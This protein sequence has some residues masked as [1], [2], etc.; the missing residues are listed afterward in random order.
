MATKL[1]TQPI[2]KYTNWA[3]DESTN[4]LPVS[5]EQVQKYI[6]D[7][8]NK[9]FGY[10][11]FDKNSTDTYDEVTITNHDPSNKY[12]IFAD[13]TDFAKWAS[14]PVD[15]SNLILFSFDAPAPATIEISDKGEQTKTLL[16]AD[17]D[18]AVLSFKYRVKKSDGSFAKSPMAYTISINNNISGVTNLPSRTLNMGSGNDDEFIQFKYEDISQ[19]LKSGINNITITLTSTLFNVSTTIIYQYNVL[20]LKLTSDFIYSSGISLDNNN[21]L[22]M[23]L[24]AEGMG[25]K[26][27]N[28]FI[29][30]ELQTDLGGNNG[31]DIYIGSGNNVQYELLIPFKNNNNQYKAWATPGMHTIQM[32][33]FI[34]DGQEQIKSK[35]LYYDFILTQRGMN[36]E[37]YI[38]FDREFAEGTIIDD[39]TVLTIETEQ[40]SSFQVKYAVYDTS[41]SGTNEDGSINVDIKLKDKN[42]S[43]P[44]TNIVFNTTASV[45]SGETSIFEYKADVAG[46][47]SLIITNTNGEIEN[48]KIINVNIIKSDIEIN[49]PKNRVLYFD[50]KNRSNAEPTE[51]RE[52]WK[53]EYNNGS[54]IV[55]YQAQFN[56]VLWNLLNGWHDN[57]LVLNNGATVT[58]PFNFFELQNQD[59]QGRGNGITFEIDFETENVQDDDAIIMEYG[60]AN[61]EHIYIKAC[62]AELQSSNANNNIHTNYKDGSRQKIQFIFGY[63]RPIENNDYSTAQ[64]YEMPYLMYIVVNGILDRVNQFTSDDAIGVN[65]NGLESFT[66]G[67]TDNKVTTKIHSISIYRRALTLDECADNYIADSDD[68]RKKYLKN[69]IYNEDG[70]TISV[71]K[72]LSTNVNVPVMTIYGDITNSIVQVFNKKSNVPVDVLYQ[73]PNYPEFNFFAR[74]A[75]LSNQGTSSMNYPRRNFRLYFNKVSDNNTLYGFASKNRYDY[76]TRVWWGLTDAETIGKIQTDPAFDLDAAI[77]LNGKT[78]TPLY[79][80]KA[81]NT[82]SKSHEIDKGTAIM[83]VHSGIKIFSDPECKNQIGKKGKNPLS[84]YLKDNPTGKIY[85]QGAY[86]RFKTKDLF[87][88]RWTLKCDYAESSMCH[89]AGIGRLWG[90]VMKNVEVGATGFR[91][92]L[93]GTKISDATPGITNAQNAAKEYDAAHKGQKISVNGKE[94]DLVFGDIR[95][96]CDGYPIIII[97]RPRIKDENGY[98]DQYDNPVFLGLYNIM[99][100]KGSTPLFG[101]EDL[102]DEDGNKRFT[103]DNTECWEC[104]QNGSNLA[105]MNDMITDDTDGSTVQYTTKYDDKG[106]LV[107]DTGSD[108]EDRPIFKTYEARWPDN[109]DLND[110]TT[111]NL[112]T[113]IR[114]VNFCKDALSVTVDG[115]DGYALSD[116]AKITEEQAEQLSQLSDASQASTIEGLENLTKWNGIIYMGV[117]G[118]SY[119]DATTKFYKTNSNGETIYDSVTLKPILLDLNDLDDK[120]NIIL[121]KLVDGKIYY[122]Q[123]YAAQNVTGQSFSP[124]YE[125]TA[126]PSERIEAIMRQLESNRPYVFTESVD[127]SSI[128]YVPQDYYDGAGNVWYILDSTYK[129]ENVKKE[130]NNTV[131]KDDIRTGRVLTYDG[132]RW[133]NREEGELLHPDAYVTVYITPR[134]S[135]Y[136]YVNEMGNTVN[137]NTSE[138]FEV[139]VGTNT[140]SGSFKGATLFDYFKDKK[141]EH[142][143]IWKL[144]C[145]YV[146]M[147]RFAAVDQVIKNTMMTTEDGRHYYFI[148]YDNDTTLGVR[149]DGYLAYDWK[150]DRETYDKSIGSFCYAGFGSVLWNLL[151]Q[152]DDFLDK[153]QKVAT[154]MVASNVLTYDIALDMFNNK[155]AGIWGERLYNNSE[156]YKYIGIYTDDENKDTDAYNPYKNTKYL[157]FLQGSRASHREWW[158]RHRFDLYDSKWSAGE[159]ANNGM[160]IYMSASASPSRPHEMY[161]IVS[162]S[163]YYY[164]VQTNGRTLGN[165]FVELE[166]GAEW[167]P[168]TTSPLAIGDPMTILGG[169]NIE[170]LDFSKN[171]NE[172]G[173]GGIEFGWNE[174]KFTSRMKQLII[175]GND[176][177]TTSPIGKIVN[178]HKLT[179]LEVLDIRTCSRLNSNPD[180]STLGA[181]RKFLAA[182]SNITSFMPAKGLILEEVSLPQTITTIKL[183]TLSINS[184]D[185]TPNRYLKSV[186]IYNVNGAAFEGNKI[187]E[188]ILNWYLSI[189]E[190]GLAVSEYKCKIGFSRIEMDKEYKVEDYPKL[191]A[192]LEE[193]ETSISCI[194]LL[195]KIKGDFNVSISQD[196]AISE[197]FSVKNGIIKIWG[198]AENKGLTNKNYNTLKNSIYTIRGRE[199]LQ[200][201]LW[202]DNWFTS[203]SVYHFDAEE[204]TF[205]SVTDIDGYDAKYIKDNGDFNWNIVSGQNAKINVIMFP[206]D[207]TRKLTFTPWY[208]NN[209]NKD[210]KWTKL[211]TG[212]DWIFELSTGTQ[213]IN[214]NNGSAT[215]KLGEN[216]YTSYK[217]TIDI[218]DNKETPQKTIYI[219][220]DK[221]VKPTDRDI[222]C[223]RNDNGTIK[224]VTSI[225]ADILSKITPYEYTV[226]FNLDSTDETVYESYDD[227]YNISINKIEASFSQNGTRPETESDLGTLE[228]YIDEETNEF[229]IRYTPKIIKNSF[230]NEATENRFRIYLWTTFNDSSKTLRKTPNISV[231][232]RKQDINSINLYYD[233]D[234][235]YI[236]NE[237]NTVFDINHY[238][239]DSYKSRLTYHY[240]I[241]INPDNYNVPIQSMTIENI[242]EGRTQ[243]TAQTGTVENNL[244][245]DFDIVYN[246]TGRNSFHITEQFIITIVTEFKTITR[247]FNVT[248]GM[249]LPDKIKLF[250]RT[251]KTG[252]EYKL[253]DKLTLLSKND[254]VAEVYNYKLFVYTTLNNEDY[255]WGASKADNKTVNNLSSDKLSRNYQYSLSFTYSDESSYGNLLDNEDIIFNG[256]NANQENTNIDAFSL[257]FDTNSM[258]DLGCKVNYSITVLGN[259]TY[260]QNF[261]LEIER[262][263]AL[264]TD[265]NYLNLKSYVNGTVTADDENSGIYFLDRNLNIYNFAGVSKQISSNGLGTY[266]IDK[267]FISMLFVYDKPEHGK[268]CLSLDF[269]KLK[270]ACNWMSTS[271]TM[272][273]SPE[274][275]FNFASTNF[276]YAI[277]GNIGNDAHMEQNLIDNCNNNLYEPMN[278]VNYKYKLPYIYSK[279]YEYY[280]YV[281]YFYNEQHVAIDADGVN[282]PFVIY[283]ND[284]NVYSGDMTQAAKDIGDNK[285]QILPEISPIKE[286]DKNYI[287]ND[288]E[289]MIFYYIN[290]LKS[291]GVQ[292]AICMPLSS[293]E[294]EIIYNHYKLFTHALS[295]FWNNYCRNLTNYPDNFGELLFTKNMIDASYDTYNE[296]GANLLPELVDKTQ[297]NYFDDY[298]ETLKQSE[299]LWVFD[300]DDLTRNSNI[301]YNY[302]SSYSFMQ[303]WMTENE[304]IILGRNIRSRV[305]TGEDTS[306]YEYTQHLLP[307]LSN[308]VLFGVYPMFF[309]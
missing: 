120:G 68:I 130:L 121:M 305:P 82:K 151:E 54:R 292:N 245:K 111:N 150:I 182:G 1:W 2:N 210:V 270:K 187:F 141:Y 7:S 27:L 176:D 212:N 5:G 300:L 224:N 6:N 81:E 289:H 230:E 35:T 303:I 161:R 189:K 60:A 142:F 166:A 203:N 199:D 251:N 244:I 198:N 202:N 302:G 276:R 38:L 11:Y 275:N 239:T 231:T 255:I 146:Y 223:S 309:S 164:T 33:F 3:G 75:W 133:K 179:A 171:K 30:G 97:N 98:T 93:E 104:L 152:D 135:G 271:S 18:T 137:Y 4:G 44:E 136:T 184:F 32:F 37:S 29:D 66:I 217:F 49:V 51:T 55:E 204:S 13:K 24:V 205:I 229:K 262:I 23:N 74:D 250:R 56:N 43:N 274:N 214:N 101:F 46:E 285:V 240:N 127:D 190:S 283:D 174:N 45:F 100:D 232:I 284:N 14:A 227:K 125:E 167:W 277:L 96:S 273:N 196:G 61:S 83:F 138:G 296:N 131:L 206:S 195:N 128:D 99:T 79:N 144:A 48:S 197:N 193:G 64:G 237:N 241:N 158:L 301:Y 116:F 124:L 168:T 117:P 246:V 258:F 132:K 139:E 177:S 278:S 70:K 234:H 281:S 65:T 249:Y 259:L 9:K 148:N 287:N 304:K 122:F 291:I 67:N 154:A 78:Y 113:V 267:F 261:D 15:N 110:T 257:T 268:Q 105:Q 191:A 47:Y 163:K 71:D 235:E 170:V 279:C 238:V 123:D 76:A 219:T 222:Y 36:H 52:I 8:L 77:E 22:S 183:D 286:S 115:R 41:G 94:Q 254:N 211:G 264:A 159:Y 19:Y 140:W 72:V 293:E 147:M 112:E 31:A 16:E 85:A 298:E 107:A 307:S 143:D 118:T 80:K 87:T 186:E 233:E 58:I 162:G 178:L 185:Y 180:I 129:R 194:D 134:G 50:A 215:L 299:I 213:L 260:T 220:S 209:N 21:E 26:Q 109:D 175:G 103:A 57:C 157:P 62:S 69:D 266:P 200:V 221:I 247:T 88:D 290:S 294:I 91:Y 225:D 114:F 108:N 126:T 84:S 226:K 90:D 28:V 243:L 216:E 308:R 156:L 160:I 149:N 86:A 165:N 269:W 201:K 242:T 173:E 252:D 59:G 248:I 288:G 92:N 306:I 119:K 20:N 207:N 95:T 253:D 102:W 282:T 236:D 25:L 89:N 297:R 188:F 280:K 272:Y 228:S 256:V 40:Y 208:K 106:K 145:Y 12:L 17:K 155:Q 63:N 192:I 295:L 218:T 263:A 172:L 73:D 153:V 169:Y 34:L 42:N 39:D 10:L 53:Y 265:F 181:L